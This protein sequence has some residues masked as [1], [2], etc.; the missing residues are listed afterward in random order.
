MFVKLL[1][2][3]LCTILGA[4]AVH[5]AGPPQVGANAASQPRSAARQGNSAMRPHVLLQVRFGDEKPGVP[6]Q[7]KLQISGVINLEV[8]TNERG[9]RAL[10]VVPK[11]KIH[12]KVFV[13]G[14]DQCDIDLDAP[15]D[16]PTTVRLFVP[17]RGVGSKCER[18]KD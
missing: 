16:K 18:L 2:A 15:G 1:C 7:A 5:A 8:S 4:A 9:E 3:S 17:K 10:P 11:G 13:A 12:L 14:A 6:A